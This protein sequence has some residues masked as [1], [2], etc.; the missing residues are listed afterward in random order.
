MLSLLHIENIAIIESADIAFEPGFNVLTGETGAGKSIVIDAISAVLGQRTSRELIRTGAKSALVTAVFTDL[1]PLTWL[2]ENGFAQG[3]ELLLQREIQGD[4][5]NAC[6]LDGRPLTVAQLREL[7]RRLLDI[8]GQHDGQQLLDPACHLTYLDSFGKTASLLADYRKAYDAM[9]ALKKRIASLEMDEAERSRR[10]DTLNYQ[11]KEL[12][13]ADL[14]PGED[15]ELDSRKALLRSAGKLMDGIQAARFALSGSE[16]SQG[17]CDLIADAEGAVR[18]IARYS[19]QTAELGEKLAALGAAAEEAAEC[20]EDLSREL[21]FSPEELDQLEGRL[22]VIYRLKKKYGATVD[23]M[24]D[25]L[26]RCRQE[27]DQIQDADDTIARLEGELAKARKTARQK[28]EAL[29]AART[30]AAA[31]LQQR[32][33]EEL[34]QLDMPKVRFE[35]EFL[36]SAGEDGMDPT[37]MDQVQ[38]LMSANVGEAL[39]PIQKVASG[40][41]LARIML[42]LKNVLAED[43]G[44]G[45]LVFDEVDTGV[46]GRAAQKVAQKM[47]DV[48]RHKQVLCVTHLPQIA[49]MADAHFSVEKGERGG[50]T[51]T[52]VERLDR[53]GREEELARL[54]GGGSV[55]GALRQS[56]GE[57]L[58]RAEEYR[59]TKS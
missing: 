38:F 41:E 34:R 51:Y 1:P 59:K 32:V 4:G 40:G 54:M 14:K 17:A 28:G 45:S 27:L 33:Q 5:R 11:I 30:E 25:Y 52:R 50:R 43:D 42:A 31:A 44:I 7:G 12:E 8:H 35:T 9:A 18:S 19:P 36:P 49:A 26:E 55:S 46:S 39:K 56:A 3:E 22:D 23:D 37:G 13:R 10:V 29:T 58:T 47:A 57:L 6:R 2:A 48:A 24:L 21:D 15:Q 16:D 53:H 20:L